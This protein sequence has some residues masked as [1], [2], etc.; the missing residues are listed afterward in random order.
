[1]QL[2]ESIFHRHSVRSYHESPLPE[3]ELSEIKGF[4]D[5]R[6]RFYP[7]IP[8]EVTLVEDGAGLQRNISGII[9]DYGKVR[10]PHYLVISSEEED[11]HLV[12]IG[13]SL[14]YLVLQL[15][16]M[17]VGTCWIGKGFKGKG[18]RE[19]VDLPSAQEARALIAFGPPGPD[20]ELARIEEPHRKE[21]GHFLPHKRESQ[22]DEKERKLIDGLRRAPSALNGQPWRVSL[23]GETVRLFIELRSKITRT[24]VGNMLTMNK[25]DG[26]IGL[27][28]LEIAGRNLWSNCSLERGAD[29][30]ADGMEYIGSLELS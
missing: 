18:L 7:A 28:H 9:A 23:E 21:L 4:L 22:L 27:S 15:T 16:R 5:D 25:I 20:E 12:D 2:Y 6:P 1:M 29:V 10:S 11:G 14:E 8:S 17:G 26:G 30:S 24:L 3:P 19:F 13:Y